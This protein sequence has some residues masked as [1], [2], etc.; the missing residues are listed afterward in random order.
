MVSK[1]AEEIISEARFNPH[2]PENIK[3]LIEKPGG[4]DAAVEA[5]I[6]LAQVVPQNSGVSYRSKHS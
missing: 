3:K 2:V 4:I 5:I 6:A 1:M